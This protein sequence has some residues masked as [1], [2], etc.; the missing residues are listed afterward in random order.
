MPPRKSRAKPKDDINADVPKTKRAPD[1]QWAKNPDWTFTL[2]A[3]LGDHVSFR[4]KLFSDSTADATKEGRAKH[5]AKD[6]K[7]QQ[8]A[9]LARHIFASEPGQRA[10]YLQN[11]G[12]YGTAVETCLRRYDH[13]LI[14]Y[15]CQLTCSLSLKSEYVVHLKALGST[16]AGLDPCAITKG[17]TIANIIGMYQFHYIYIDYTN[18]FHTAGIR[19][20]WPWWDDLHAYWR[21]LP[22]YNPQGVQ[23]SEPG[24]MHGSDAA[25]L[26]SAAN[27]DEEL[28][29]ENV[30]DGGGVG[31]E[32]DVDGWDSGGGSPVDEG[33]QDAI[34]VRLFLKEELR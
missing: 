17:S 10:L 2:I 7:A 24:T 5:T 3:Y 25:A 15:F 16:G 6:G 4:L 22:N 12:R 14:V 23:S 9:V 32:Q 26:F 8:Y 11:P 21:E 31:D 19:S 30:L 28:E 33:D 13:L 29:I 1:I 27:E 20:E 34:P 18:V